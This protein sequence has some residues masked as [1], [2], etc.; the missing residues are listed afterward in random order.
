MSFPL[1]VTLGDGGVNFS[2]FSKHARA[3]QLL[4]FDAIDAPRVS[5]T[6]DLVPPAHR[7]YHYWHAFVPGVAAGQVYAYRAA[8]PFAPDKGLRFDAEKVLLDPYGRCIARPRARSRLAAG[9][10][11][12][13]AATAYCSLVVDPRAYFGGTTARRVV[14]SRRPSSTRCTSATSRVVR[15]PVWPPR[16]AAPSPA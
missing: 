4:L 11:G 6:V 8:G 12:D 15:A 9:L 7:T 14:P 13:N 16:G 3:L 2:V 1:G 5:R 10:P